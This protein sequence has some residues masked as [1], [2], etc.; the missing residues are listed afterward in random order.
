MA[1]GRRGGVEEGLWGPT[2]ELPRPPG[3]PFY[4][5]VN[6]VLNVAGFDRFVEDL[7]RPHYA[8]VQ[9]QPSIPAGTYFRM[10]M[11]GYFEGAPHP[12][13]DHAEQIR[14]SSTGC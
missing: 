12:S 7:C 11:V 1:L 2:T 10:L 9:G 3:H 5:R 4:E 8:A 14:P 6:Q 13:P